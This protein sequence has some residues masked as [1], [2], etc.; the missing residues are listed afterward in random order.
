[1][2]AV[3][4][5]VEKGFMF[6]GGAELATEVEDGVAIFQRKVAEKI[7]QLLKAVA[8]LRWVGFVGFCVG[9]V[10]LIQDGFAIGIAQIDGC[11][12]M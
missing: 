11:L 7:L 2:C 3:L 9:L 5:A 4:E 10:K 12:S 1:M 6:V 8:D